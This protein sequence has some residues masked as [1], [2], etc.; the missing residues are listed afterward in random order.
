MERRRVANWA[1]FLLTPAAACLLCSCTNTNRTVTVECGALP[2]VSVSVS[3]DDF[4]EG[5]TTW[6][7]MTSHPPPAGSILELRPQTLRRPAGQVVSTYTLNVSARDFLPPRQDSSF[8]SVADAAFDLK[9]APDVSQ[10]QV[11]KAASLISRIVQNTTAVVG[12]PQRVM[13]RDP[14]AVLNA[15]RNAQEIIRMGG[16]QTRFLM[17][18]GLLYGSRI[19]L[20]GLNYSK[21]PEV[22]VNTLEI[23]D[24]YLHYKFSCSSIDAINLQAQSSGKPIP[25]AF[26]YRRVKRSEAGN[27][28]WS[29]TA[30]PDLGS[31]IIEIEK[32]EHE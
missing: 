4:F 18:I 9:F 5:P 29:D 30:S 1:H 11:T 24:V 3:Q 6:G 31:S 20:I 26:I 7:L 19:D 16:A 28:A 14:L 13:L 12:E 32:V 23:G 21:H 25:V 27:I 10:D 22:A 8:W 17:V 2:G 15:D